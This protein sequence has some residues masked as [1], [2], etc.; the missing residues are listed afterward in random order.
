MPSSVIRRFDYDARRCELRIT[1]VTGRAYVYEQ[2]P[3]AIYQ[4]FAA[5][6][7][8]GSF[9][10]RHIRDRYRFREFDAEQHATHASGAS[11]IGS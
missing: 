1:F 8:K 2:V 10:N 11:T 7:A 4:S 6:F 5:A 9:F 3:A